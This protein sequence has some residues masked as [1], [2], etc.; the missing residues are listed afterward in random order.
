M[1]IKVDVCVC[2][3]VIIQTIIF[4]LRM[5]WQSV[6]SKQKV[7]YIENTTIFVAFF[8]VLDFISSLLILTA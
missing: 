4:I 2:V 8:I 5:Y 6:P 1:L 3:C 7:T